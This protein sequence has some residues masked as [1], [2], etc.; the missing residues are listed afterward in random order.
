M[1]AHPGEKQLCMSSVTRP[2]EVPG[3]Q[4]VQATLRPYSSELL[5]STRTELVGSP[6]G[7]SK[8]QCVTKTKGQKAEG[9]HQESGGE[10]QPAGKPSAAEPA[11]WKPTSPPGGVSHK[12]E[13]PRPM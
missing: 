11:G 4:A 5:E 10:A 8:S 9:P 12:D 6:Q 13:G 1:T 2:R 3:G 7:K